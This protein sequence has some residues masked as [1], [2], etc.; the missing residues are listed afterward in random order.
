MMPPPPPSRTRVPS[1]E[2]PARPPPD[3]KSSKARPPPEFDV[4]KAKGPPSAAKG[5]PSKPKPP[6]ADLSKTGLH[7]RDMPKPPPQPPVK[8]PPPYNDTNIPPWRPDKAL[9]KA[10]LNY[11][12]PTPVAVK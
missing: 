3:S 2:M 5:M 1:T 7:V 11:V 4:S 9:V 6:I 12:P 10:P 8:A